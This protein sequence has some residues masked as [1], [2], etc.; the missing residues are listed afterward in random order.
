[1]RAD[2]ESPI[3]H[4]RPVLE[5]VAAFKSGQC[6]IRNF[7]M[8][9]SGSCKAAPPL[10]CRI[11]RRGRQESRKDKRNKR[12]VGSIRPAFDGFPGRITASYTRF[13]STSQRE[14]PRSADFFRGGRKP[15]LTGR[16]GDRRRG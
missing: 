1:M 9:V 11:W 16:S 13:M 2:A 3:G 10:P 8:N 4:V 14:L 7:I 15:S 5:V 12:H 6:P